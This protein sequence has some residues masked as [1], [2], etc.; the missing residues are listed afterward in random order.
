[1][2]EVLRGSP[3]SAPGQSSSNERIDQPLIQVEETGAREVS[4][5]TIVSVCRGQYG[6]QGSGA[7]G[8]AALLGRLH[9]A[10]TGSQPIVAVGGTERGACLAEDRRRLPR[11]QVDA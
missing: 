1:M 2:H 3:A 9:F 5:V 8:L 6:A 11:A 4:E 7:I 10:L